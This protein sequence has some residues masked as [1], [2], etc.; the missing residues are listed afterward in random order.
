MA[1]VIEIEIL[2]KDGNVEKAF[3]K[4]EKRAEELGKKI[5]GSV[6]K[7]TEG[8]EKSLSE[9]NPL[10]GNTVSKL[11]SMAPALLGI[12]AAALTVKGLFEATFEAERLN[13]VNNQFELLT[14]NVGISGD[15]LRESFEGAAQ[16]LVSTDNIL[17]AAN[18]SVSLLGQ[19]ASQLGPIFE[20]AIKA[21]AITGGDSIQIFEG[22]SN[23]IATGNT[24]A[25]RQIGIYLDADEAIKK[26]A[27]SIGSSANALSEAGKQQAILNAIL[28]KSEKNFDGIDVNASKATSA[29]NRFKVALE[30][31]IQELSKSVAQS[32]IF[33]QIFNTLASVITNTTNILK[34]NFGTQLDQL[35]SKQENLNTQIEQTTILLKNL[36]ASATDGRDISKGV[37]FFNKQLAESRLQLSLVN[38]QLLRLEQQKPKNVSVPI[39]VDVEKQLQAE[40]SVN[41]KLSQM[42]QQAIAEELQ[43]A[44]DA[45]I[46]K[47]LV[48]EQELLKKQAFDLQIAQLDQQARD[49]GLINDQAYLDQRSM[50]VESYNAASL[51]R[52]QEY[53]TR[54]IAIGKQVTQ[55]IQ[56]QLAMGV[57]RSIAFITESLIKGQLSFEAFGRFI[58]GVLGDAAIQIGTM[59][60]AAGLAIDSI[61]KLT[62]TQAVIA[63]AA[64]IAIGSVMKALSGG[65]GLGGGA[66]ASAGGGFSGGFGG[67]T[68]ATPFIEE[69]EIEKQKESTQVTVNVQGNILDRRETGLELAAIIAESFD[70]NGTKIITGAV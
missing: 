69:P 67:A 7:S 20:T 4:M 45:S 16:G 63:G 54:A 39:Q 14:R 48:R 5:D 66:G 9:I 52:Q 62:G 32:D 13:A 53:A 44:T 38:E 60:I 61:G 17:Q 15:A 42:R 58:L 56:S 33:A 27:A 49:A 26:Y 30:D 47:D 24:R 22:L 35:K 34:T 41:Q 43:F 23:A 51:A 3:I 11:A 36:Q 29:Y 50:L 18:R 19:N 68:E 25:L 21:A 55:A 28:E 2:T 6:G 57:A 65:G 46:Q 40:A 10:L 59:A 64:L 8:L 70:I 37:E 1:E 31:V 12:G